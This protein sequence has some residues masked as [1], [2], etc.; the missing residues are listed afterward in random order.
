M[1]G[2][3][4]AADVLRNGALQHA[5]GVVAA[6]AYYAR[7]A[8]ALHDAEDVMDAMKSVATLALAAEGLRDAANAVNE[9]SRAVLAEVMMSTGCGSVRTETHSVGVSE[10]RRG[11]VITDPS[12]VPETMMNAPTAPSPN[13]ALILKALLAGDGLP[14]AELTNGGAPYLTFRSIKS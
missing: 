5:P 13:R 2:A 6:V 10:G 9:A 4:E 11:L 3:V 14:F 8:E 7:C 1:S 12:A